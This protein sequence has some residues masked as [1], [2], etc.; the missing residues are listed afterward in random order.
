MQ[1]SAQP[2]SSCLKCNV[3]FN[4]A[5]YVEAHPDVQPTNLSPGKVTA[6][7]FLLPAPPL[8]LTRCIKLIHLCMGVQVPDAHSAIGRHS[9]VLTPVGQAGMGASAFE[10]QASTGSS[11]PA[12]PHL[13]FLVHEACASQTVHLPWQKHAVLHQQHGIAPKVCHAS[14]CQPNLSHEII[15][16]IL[17]HRSSH[18]PF[19]PSPLR[20]H[21]HAVHRPAV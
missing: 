8:C 10:Q 18:R 3:S 19:T 4:F 2:A 14:T 13:R 7:R 11:I 20:V 9:A 16:F 17:C 15:F 12:M 5:W 1:A 6:Q 21:C